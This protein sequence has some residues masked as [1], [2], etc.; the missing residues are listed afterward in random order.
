MT[1]NL[2]I[3]NGTREPDAMDALQGITPRPMLGKRLAR[4]ASPSWQVD[5][6]VLVARIRSKLASL[7]DQAY[8]IGVTAKNGLVTL[9]GKVHH[10]EAA[11]LFF[12]IRAMDGVVDVVDNLELVKRA[13][14]VHKPFPRLLAPIAALAGVSTQFLSRSR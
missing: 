8:L 11:I 9:T 14:D 3:E 6:D 1:P 12:A 5:D 4:K 13:G 2:E 10:D 7:T